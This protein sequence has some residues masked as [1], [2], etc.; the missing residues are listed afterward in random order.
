VVGSTQGLR[1]CD[2][3]GVSGSLRCQSQS[4]SEGTSLGGES[5]AWQAWRSLQRAVQSM[6]ERA[7]GHYPCGVLLLREILPWATLAKSHLTSLVSLLWV[8]TSEL[9]IW[10][11]LVFGAVVERTVGNALSEALQLEIWILTTHPTYVCMSSSERYRR[12]GRAFNK[13]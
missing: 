11:P 6:E 1:G 5:S 13:K 3:A 10:L 9:D 7:D 8:D 12:T 4:S 2:G